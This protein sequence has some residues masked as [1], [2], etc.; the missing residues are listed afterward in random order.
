MIRIAWIAISIIASIAV[1][2]AA[3]RDPAAFWGMVDISASVLAIF[4]G[5]SIAVFTIL[6]SRPQLGSNHV[7]DAD[8]RANAQVSLDDEDNALVLQQ[9]ILFSVYM[10]A[11][12]LALAVKFFS[13]DVD[14]AEIG[15]L[16]RVC[17]AAY[18]GVAML[19]FLLSVFLP[20]LAAGLVR[21]RRELS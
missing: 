6:A 15:I 11:I 20:G 21:Q 7:P 8:Q 9:Y 13:S 2:R 1:G 4:V 18:G 3:W 5:V 14:D 16:L 12:G 19:A 17:T 10:V